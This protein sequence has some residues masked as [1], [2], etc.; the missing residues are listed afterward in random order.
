MT[1]RSTFPGGTSVTMLE[2]YAD[3]AQDAVCGGSPHMH[4]ASTECYVVVGG[5]GALH[6]LN[7]SGYSETALVEGTVTWFTPGTIHRAVNHGGLKILVIM[8][9]AGLPEAGDAVMTF[10]REI[11]ADPAVYA[12][13]ARLPRDAPE[14]ETARAAST[15]RDLAVAGF[16]ELRARVEAGDLTALH[17]FYA[18][19]TRIVG[20]QATLWDRIV[21]E[22]PLRQATESLEMARAVAHG[23]T[24]HLVDAAVHV[25]EVPAGQPGYGMCGRLRAYDVGDPRHAS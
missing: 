13:H 17:D 11:L 8:S 3:A 12:Q 14:W 5:E 20:H 7:G 15:R 16:L 23:E 2:V 6:T 10:P 24:R 22:R 9:N 1:D 25:G 19:A 4:L 21:R 18:D